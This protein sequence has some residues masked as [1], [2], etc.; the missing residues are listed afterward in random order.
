MAATIGTRMSTGEMMNNV[1]DNFKTTLAAGIADSPAL[2]A[3]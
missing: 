2:Y 3:L 1:I